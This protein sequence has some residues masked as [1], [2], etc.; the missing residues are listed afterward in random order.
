[1]NRQKTVECTTRVSILSTSKT[2][3]TM[4]MSKKEKDD[5]NM[6]DWSKL[7]SSD[8]DND[9]D[10]EPVEKP[11]E[12]KEPVAEKEVPPPVTRPADTN[13]KPNWM[14]DDELIEAVGK[15]K[16]GPWSLKIVYCFDLDS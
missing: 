15:N 1:M 2:M 12:K 13:K 11:Q 3:T 8:S 9:S 16:R 7:V 5:I 14:T 4:K 6:K 10:E